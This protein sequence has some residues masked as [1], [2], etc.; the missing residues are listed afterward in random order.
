MAP[1]W[2]GLDAGTTGVRC[3]AFDADCTVAA[4]AYVENPPVYSADGRVEQ[5]PESW[6]TASMRVLRTV[7]DEVGTDAVQALSISSQGISVV[8]VDRTGR[9]L[10][11]A[12]IWL[13]ERGNAVLDE[14]GALIDKDSVTERSGKPWSGVYTL[15]K[16][17]W[18][19]RFEPEIFEEADAFL[20][21]MDYLHLRLVG[22]AITDHTLASATMA[23]SLRDGT[24]DRESLGAIGVSPDLFPTIRDSGSCAGVLR[25]PIAAE[26]GIRR[27]PV[28]VGGQDQKLAA[29]GAGIAPGV[30]TLCLGTSGALESLADSP[31]FWGGPVFSFLGS[32]EYVREAAIPTAGAAHRWYVNN[33]LPGGGYDLSDEMSATGPSANAPYFFARLSD[34]S[35][36]KWPTA[37]GGLFWG[38]RLGTDTADL[39]RSVYEGIAFEI[40]AWWERMGLYGASLRVFGGGAR[41]APWCRIIASTMGCGVE[42]LNMPEASALGAALLAGLPPVP[43]ASERIRVRDDEIRREAE[44]FEE[45][46]EIRD[47]VYGSPPHANTLG[48]CRPETGGAPDLHGPAAGVGRWEDDP[49]IR[50]ESRQSR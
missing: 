50:P 13:D 34:T 19:K 7:I 36:G 46:K 17:Y 27:I 2:L 20:Q 5:D 15:P 18:L 25:E 35:A 39:A 1:V 12:I 14:L 11:N 41:S 22:E 49:R 32:G 43:I 3:L 37:P 48:H 21:P 6:F 16:V 26:L 29:F 45:W 23:Y 24:W 31:T 33:A 44:R 42:R 4:S 8:P 38:I 10:R 9:P 28:R 47:G 30:A 40:A